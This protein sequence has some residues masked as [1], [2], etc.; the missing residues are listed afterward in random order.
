MVSCNII[1]LTTNEPH[2]S[3]AQESE[4]NN[5]KKFEVNSSYYE[6]GLT[7]LITGRTEKAVK[8]VEVQHAGRFNERRSKEK[9]AT[10]RIWNDKEIL[11][12]GSRTIEA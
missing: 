9:R 2:Q 5:M 3:V 4:E 7:F 6:S 11:L 1:S 12:I 8:Y 10:L